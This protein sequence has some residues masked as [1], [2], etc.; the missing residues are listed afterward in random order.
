MNDAASIAATEG[1]PAKAMVRGDVSLETTDSFASIYHTH[2][3]AVAGLIYRRTGDPHV[4]E[5]LTADVFVAAYRSI[6]RFQPSSVPLSAWLLRIATNKV[7]RWARRRVGLAGILKRLAY[8]RPVEAPAEPGMDYPSALAALLNLPAHYQAVISLHHLEG[9]AL[10]EVALVLECR[11][12]A[13]KSRLARAREALR[14]E[15]LRQGEGS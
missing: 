4:T 5:D 8:V 13:V 10:E 2:Y 1:G 11:V 3:R 7:N 14:A 6:D 12:T 9:L 15:L